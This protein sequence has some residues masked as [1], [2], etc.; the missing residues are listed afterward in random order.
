M[1]W[2]LTDLALW[3]SYSDDRDVARAA[4][5][6]L[7]YLVTSIPEQGVLLAEFNFLRKAP[8]AELFA[9]QDSTLFRGE[10]ARDSLRQ[11]FAR[12]ILLHDRVFALSDQSK[13]RHYLKQRFDESHLEDGLHHK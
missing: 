2:C 3:R 7:P 8:Y 13:T 1:L 9:N 11:R 4:R 5:D 6:L 12:M 10:N